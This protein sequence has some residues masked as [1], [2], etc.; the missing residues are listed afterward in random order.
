MNESLHST[1]DY[2]SY[3]RMWEVDVDRPVYYLLIIL[4][5]LIHPLG[6]ANITHPSPSV[7]TVNTV[8]EKLLSA[9]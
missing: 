8:T 7:D 2:L 9:I 5:I 4:K 6:V 1:I 3:T